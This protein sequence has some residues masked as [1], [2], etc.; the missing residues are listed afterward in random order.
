M[1]QVLED[2]RTIILA[3]KT[4]YIITKVDCAIET[5]LYQRSISDLIPTCLDSSQDIFNFH[6]SQNFILD[7]SGKIKLDNKNPQIKLSDILF[8]FEPNFYFDAAYTGNTQKRESFRKKINIEYGVTLNINN[9]YK[10][11][12]HI[13]N[14][15]ERE[16]ALIE[17]NQVLTLH[18][19]QI[20][21]INPQ[22]NLTTLI[23]IFN[24]YLKEKRNIFAINYHN[25]NNR[26][27]HSSKKY[28][29]GEYGEDLIE[30]KKDGE[31]WIIGTEKE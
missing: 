25:V 12:G 20:D 30:S 13:W 10:I 17:P 29:P 7:E 9:M 26:E 24:Q 6:K 4:G 28:N 27:I 16:Q 14:L 15:E 23:N 11:S 19:A 31:Y 3:T 1:M 22:A 21:W 18:N 2:A 5:M 8:G